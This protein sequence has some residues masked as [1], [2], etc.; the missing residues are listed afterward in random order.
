MEQE[1]IFNDVEQAICSF[2]DVK[3]EEVYCK[4]LKRDI[5]LVR[6]FTIYILHTYYNVS[7]SKLHKRY[8]C[9]VR[10]VVRVCASI[11]FLIER[12]KKYRNY[13]NCLMQYIKKGE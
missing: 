2:F 9:S 13:Y 7:L 4:N 1:I 10:T 8:K 5:A 6:H 12:D 3:K 11:R